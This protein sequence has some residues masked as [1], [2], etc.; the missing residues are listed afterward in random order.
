MTDERLNEGQHEN[1]TYK[2]LAEHHNRE[3]AYCEELMR[4]LSQHATTTFT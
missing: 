3:R 4:C 1:S 2:N